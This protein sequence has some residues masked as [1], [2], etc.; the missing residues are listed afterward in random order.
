MTLLSRAACLPRASTAEGVHSLSW[1]LLF[2]FHFL[3]I[4]YG[5]ALDEHGR[6][7]SAGTYV[8]VCFSL[9][10]GQLLDGG[11]AAFPRDS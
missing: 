10:R 2:Y 3:F 6:I 4:F 11:G 1:I 8:V 5:E 9:G 7:Y